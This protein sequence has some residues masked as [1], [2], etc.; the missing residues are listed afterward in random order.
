VSD[1]EREA[2]MRTPLADAVTAQTRVGKRAVFASERALAE[3]AAR[4]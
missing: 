1:G 3:A 4:R 2:F